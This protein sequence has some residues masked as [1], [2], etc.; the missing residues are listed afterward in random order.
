M[1]SLKLKP[2]LVSIVVT[3]T[4]RGSTGERADPGRPA[5]QPGPQ[6]PKPPSSSLT[7]RPFFG[8]FKGELIGLE[9]N[10]LGTQVGSEGVK[11]NNLRGEAIDI[12]P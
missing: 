8:L 6:A 9:P 12:I 7:G 3:G 10:A 2:A 5:C 1:L 11:A 4:A